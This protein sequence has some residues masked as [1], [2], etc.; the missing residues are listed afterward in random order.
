MRSLPLRDSSRFTLLPLIRTLVDITLLRKG[1][2]AIPNAWVLLYMSFG[3]WIATLLGTVGLIEQFDA[4]NAWVG[5]GSGIVGWSCYVVVLIGLG[6]GAR[7]IPTLTAIVGSGA[8]ISFLMLAAHV[9]LTPT[10]GSRIADLVTFFILVWSVPVKGNIIARA[11]NWHWYAG[12]VIA[13]S[14]FLLQLAFTQSMS[15]QT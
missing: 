5:L 10:L 4:N 14:I 12:I 9:T 7:T 15:A 3:L 8:V 11:V 13:F 2:E 1:P 6:F